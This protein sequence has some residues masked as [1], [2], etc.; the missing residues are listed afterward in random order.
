VSANDRFRAL[1]GVNAADALPLPHL[2]AALAQRILARTAH[3]P[4]FA[5]S[6]TLIHNQDYGTTATRDLLDFAYVH[7]LTGLCLHLNDGGKS[8]VGRMTG[9][10]RER[11]RAHYE[12]L[13]LKLHLEISATD[14]TE[15]DRAVA[16][17][18]DLGVRNIRV[19]AR[20]E[21]R[22]SAVIEKIYAD[23]SHAAEC[24]NRHGLNIDY[25]QH[26]DLRAAEIAGILSRI[27]DAR[28]NALFDYTNSLNAH[29]EPLDALRIL[30]RYI[31]QVH[32]KGGRKIVEGS[33]WGQLGVAQGNPDDALPGNRMLYELLMLGENAPQVVCFAL[34]QEVGYYA[35]PFRLDGEEPDPLIKFREPSE[36]PL[37]P[38]KPLA[39]HLLDERRWAIGQIAWNRTLVATLREICASSLSQSDDRD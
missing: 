34:E 32:I 23:M 10:D 4:F 14:R 1:L 5:H 38:N 37:D 25:E 24:A 3:V 16:C 39:R 7:G 19:Y 22:L 21:G 29:E 18:L 26:E 13:G 12:S 36:T 31:R 6:Y 2:D 20:Y 9:A 27:G 15:I 33:G 11:F 28:I 35:P 17:A 30:A 8:A